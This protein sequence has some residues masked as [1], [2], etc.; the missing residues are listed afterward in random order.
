MYML[1]R[2]YYLV[3]GINPVA[4][5][6]TQ[7]I[8][9]CWIPLL[10]RLFVD[11]MFFWA[12]FTPDFGTKV[13]DYLGWVRFS[14]VMSLIT[15]YAVFAASFGFTVDTISDFAL[16]KIPFIKDILPQMPPPLNTNFNKGS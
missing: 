5:N 8:Q 16:S 4:N 9:R 15:Q 1:K 6:Y 2:A 11:S 12:L 13:L 10:I 14:W 7:F 3:T